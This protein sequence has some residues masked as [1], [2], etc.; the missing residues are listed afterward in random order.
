M[1]ATG[2]RRMIRIARR[3]LAGA[4]PPLWGASIAG[5]WLMPDGVR[6]VVVAA[7]VAATVAGLHEANAMLHETSR[8]QDKDV[9]MRAVAE[10]AI[11][12][13]ARSTGPMRRAPGR[14]A[15]S[16]QPRLSLLPAQRE[17]DRNAG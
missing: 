16:V 7:T 14:H 8:D 5:I 3:T 12:R 15:A 6:E 17:T 2:S 9:L 4:A 1:P 10:Q 13:A 11:R